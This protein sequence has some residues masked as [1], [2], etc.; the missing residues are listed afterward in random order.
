MI[1]LSAPDIDET[2]VAAVAAVLR[3]GQLVQGEKIK[4]FEARIA[5]ITGVAHAIAVSN[6]TTALQLSLGVLGLKPGDEVAV[7]AYSWP[8]T[9][10]AIELT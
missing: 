9:A 7:P 10:N 4:E 1:R 5:A 8:A 6:C 2:D 3:S